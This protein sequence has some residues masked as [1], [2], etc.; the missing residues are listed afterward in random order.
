MGVI[1]TMQTIGYP[2]CTS[3]IS[4]VS[5]PGQV[6]YPFS[7]VRLCYTNFM[8]RKYGEAKISVPVDLQ[9]RVADMAKANKTSPS[10][11]IASLMRKAKSYRMGATGLGE[12]AVSYMS[13]AHPERI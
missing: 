1:V 13:D 2:H 8:P 5:V 9:N 6:P 3:Y 10:R 7:G 4:I 12:R 11:L